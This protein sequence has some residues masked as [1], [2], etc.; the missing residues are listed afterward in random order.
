MSYIT[1]LT[2]LTKD[3]IDKHGISMA[4]AMVTLRR[5]L[6]PNAILVGQNI[7]KDVQWLGL[8]EGTDYSSLIDLSALFQVWNPQRNSMTG[9]GQDH[10]AKV[11]LGIHDSESHDALADAVIS[12]SLFNAYRSVQDDPIRLSQLQYATLSA[13]RLPSFSAANPTV[14]NCCMGNRKKCTCGAPWL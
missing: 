12:V 10:C 2:G 7:L 14:D 1:P 9:F 4:E 8:V 6:P 5:N 11:W 3:L 13:P